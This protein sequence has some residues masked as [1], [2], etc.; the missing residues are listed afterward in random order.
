MIFDFSLAVYPSLCFLGSAIVSL[1]SLYKH[2]LPKGKLYLVFPAIDIFF[3]VSILVVDSLGWLF[4]W[5]N[6]LLLIP[7]FAYLVF[8]S[9]Y[10]KKMYPQNTSQTTLPDREDNTDGN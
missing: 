10:S 6:I 9:R 7:C 4:S 5:L 1:I 3:S 8:R 2:G